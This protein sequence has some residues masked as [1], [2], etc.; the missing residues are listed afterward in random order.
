LLDRLTNTLSNEKING[1]ILLVHCGSQAT[2]D[3]LPDILDEFAKRGIIV[4][5]LSQ[6]L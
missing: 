3:A 4:T 5:T 6:V 1:A 2:A